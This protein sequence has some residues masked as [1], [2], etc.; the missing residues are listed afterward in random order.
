[1]HDI[2]NSA[3]S[4][5]ALRPPR[6]LWISPVDPFQH[7]GHLRCRDR[8]RTVRRRGPD[9]LAAVQ[10]LGVKRQPDAVMPQ[11]LGQIAATA[12]EDI[13]ITGMGIA[14]QLLL[15]RQSQALQAPAHVRVPGRD[16]DPDATRN[17][18]HR[19][20]RMESTR[21]SAATSTPAS[22]MTRRCFPISISMRPLAGAA[23]TDSAG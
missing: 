23:G 12:T 20:A 22:T 10:T 5:R 2:P 19:R 6:Q 1:M 16:P 14:L 4:A 21:A 15:N 13:E 18:D 17:R 8:H 9:E 11:N 7:I 3:R